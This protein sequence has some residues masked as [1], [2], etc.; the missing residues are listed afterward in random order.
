[1]RLEHEMYVGLT[2]EMQ[3]NQQIFFNIILLLLLNITL[4]LKNVKK[5]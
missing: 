1:M 4:L 3:I 5:Y 2:R